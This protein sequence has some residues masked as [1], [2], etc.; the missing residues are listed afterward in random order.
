M[1]NVVSKAAACVLLLAT[2]LPVSA[3]AASVCQRLNAKLSAATVTIGNTK[4]TRKYSQAII[5]QKREMKKVQAD[6]RR[7]GCSSG[8]IIVIGGANAK[9]CRLLEKTIGRMQKNLRA[10]EA[11]KRKLVSPS[12]SASERRRIQA[13]LQANGCNGLRDATAAHTE[14]ARKPEKLAYSAVA[15]PE[16]TRAPTNKG[17]SGYQV[18]S[19]GGA[20]KFGNFRT[21]CV[22]TCDGGFFPI[23]SNASSSDFGR[24]AQVCSMMCPGISTEL[25][26]HSVASQESSAMVSAFD[27]APYET[28]PF[29]YRYR[30]VG[31]DNSQSCSCNF[32]A[33]Y[34]EMLRRETGTVLK[35]PQQT[36][37]TVARL[38]LQ[39]QLRSS[40]PV[41]RSAAAQNRPYDPN[42]VSI[43]KVGPEFLPE[44]TAL[45][46]ANPLEGTS[47]N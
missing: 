21:V 43:R 38:Q 27:G 40:L 24:D 37:A 18:A 41:E 16:K 7:L 20:G 28:R 30:N 6:L 9:H 12:V 22:R 33:Y 39:S 25:F 10:L 47:T 4:S 11:Q 26:Y 29:A 34:R 14:K 44:E 36:E 2:V 32:S 1:R 31:T 8:S 15:E 17:A 46:L 13:S 23:S 5:R 35:N 42:A 45:D 19:L 3:Q